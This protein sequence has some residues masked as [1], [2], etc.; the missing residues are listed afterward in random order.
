MEIKEAAKKH[1]PEITKLWM[2]F[3][4]FNADIEPIDTSGDK[5]L[6]QVEAHLKNRITSD[7]SLVLVAIADQKAVG[8]SISEI[9]KK[10][11]SVR[12][13]NLGIIY[14]MVITADQR[15][16][17]FGKEMLDRIKTWF[18]DRDI[19]RIEISAVTKNTIGHTFWREQ[20]F[21]DYEDIMYL[22][23]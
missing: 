12:K 3:M 19:K 22:E 4:Y 9:T 1:I 15:G 8:Y 17:G 18:K 2:E 13:K 7:D 23:N 11:P 10:S 16:K 5:V 14:D 6:T 21:Q 20:G